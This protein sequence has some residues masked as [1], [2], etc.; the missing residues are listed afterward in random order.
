MSQPVLVCLGGSMRET[1]VTAAAL[2]AIAEI[3]TAKQFTVHLL[4]IRVLN[5][6]MYHSE[7]DITDYPAD[8]QA[9]IRTLLDYCRRADAFVFAS[10]VYHGTVSGS[11][12]NAVDFIEFMAEDERPYLSERA[13]GLITTNDARTFDSMMH[14][15]HELR[16]WLAP[17]QLVVRKSEFDAHRVLVDEGVKR[18]MNR[19]VDELFWFAK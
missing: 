18:R 5:L 19:L 17:T 9:S 14:I 16:G 2:R 1:S 12:K 10:P 13:I 15:V 11:F 4:D 3:A 7:Y 8:S 6:P